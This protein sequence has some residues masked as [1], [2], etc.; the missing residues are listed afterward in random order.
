MWRLYEVTVVLVLIAI[1]CQNTNGQQ[2]YEVVDG[3]NNFA[4]KLLEETS[5]QVNENVALSPFTI[6]YLLFLIAEGAKG[7]T[8]AQLTNVLLNN[9]P[10]D[11]T[12]RNKI[13]NLSNGFNINS[14]GVK[15]DISNAIFTEHQIKPEYKTKTA[16][17]K[18]FT[19]QVN[20]NQIDKT[21]QLINNYIAQATNNR[22]TDL[23]KPDDIR[24][25]SVFITST[26]FF[27]GEWTYPFDKQ[28]TKPMP[29]YD[30][31]G[32]NIGKFPLMFQAGPFPYLYISQINA[33]V[34]E[35]PYGTE[36]NK[37]AMYVVLPR[38]NDTVD[39]VLKNMKN[40]PFRTIM[41]RLDVAEQEYADDGISLF[42]P[43]FN[44]ESEYILNNVLD[45]LGITE[46]F[47]VEKADLTDMFHHYLFISRV[48][49]KA[50]ISVD[51]EGTIAA[52]AAGAASINKTIQPKVR[53]DKPFA[54]FI[55]DKVN[56]NIIFS[57]KV[58][59]PNSK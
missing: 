59:N 48:L 31:H 27:K 23:V 18:I 55:A 1:F 50:M 9:K 39:N 2:N 56:R 49:Q 46:M 37:M 11:N 32:K 5:R 41:D 52:A 22:I 28:Y 13:I 25:A 17:Y 57:G 20:F 15:L 36:G 34:V 10:I 33:N 38:G 14:E 12:V 54:Y 6:W 45:Q 44:V 30:E 43:K 53:V 7:N 58:V 21:V 24:K 4:V 8:K 16:P 3:L 51:E 42:L 47:D 26:L 35:I 29:F 19:S 40:I